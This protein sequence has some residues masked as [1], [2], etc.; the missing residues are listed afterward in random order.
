MLL[1]YA[2]TG[3]YRTGRFNSSATRGTGV[4]EHLVGSLNPLALLLGEEVRWLRRADP[5]NDA[6]LRQDVDPLGQQD[7]PPP[8]AQCDERK[9][10]IIVDVLDHEA[11]LVQVRIE[12]YYG[13]GV[14]R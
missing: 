4:D 11:H 10:S 2:A 1:P 9:R 7:V 12:A 8:A 6:V 14:Q 3:T 13:K 5:R